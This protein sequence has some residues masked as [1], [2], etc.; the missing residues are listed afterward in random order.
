[1]RIDTRVTLSRTMH[2]TK[3][4]RRVALSQRMHQVESMRS[5]AFPQRM[6]ALRRL[7]DSKKSNRPRRKSESIQVL[8]L[9]DFICRLSIY[10][11]ILEVDILPHSQRVRKTQISVSQRAET[12]AR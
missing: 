5:A 1:M 4:M 2:R 10:A 12:W 6:S 11:K 3:S 8:I 9:V 7:E